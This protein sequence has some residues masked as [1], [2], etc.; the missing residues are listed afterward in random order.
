MVNVEAFNTN[1]TEAQLNTA[2]SRAL[3]DYTDAQID[4]LIA[5]AVA[6]IGVTVSVL[7]ADN[8]D[9]PTYDTPTASAGILLTVASSANTN[10]G[11]KICANTSGEIFACAKQDSSTWHSWAELVSL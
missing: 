6:G 8:A 3:G 4:S 11:L 2:F 9:N 7:A 1:L 10:V 5:A